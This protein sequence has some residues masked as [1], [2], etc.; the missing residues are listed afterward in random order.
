MLNSIRKFSKTILAKIILV[1]IIIPFVFW[2]MGSVFNT[3]SSNTI[4]KINNHNISTQDFLD[5]LN[6]SRISSKAIKDNLDKNILEEVLGDLISNKMLEMEIKNLNIMVSEIALVKEIKSNKNF[7]DENNKFS[8]PKY[9]KFLISQ[10]LDAPSFEIILKER[11]LKNSLFKYISGGIISPYF[12]LNNIFTNESKKID[13]KMIN[14]LNLY[15]KHNEFNDDEINDFFKKNKTTL[16]EEFIN[17]SY[18]KITPENLIGSSEYNE[19]FFEEIDELENKI[20]KGVSFAEIIND[21]KIEYV[22]KINYTPSKSKN[23]KLEKK[24]YQLRNENKI[25][26]ID[27]NDFFLLFEIS[28]IYKKI[29]NINDEDVKDKIVT[30]LYEKNKNDFN[31]KLFKK[32]TKKEFDNKEFIKLAKEHKLKILNLK[33]NSINDNEILNKDSI[34]LLYSMPEGSFLLIIDKLKNV[35]VAK[36][37]KIYKNNLEK[38]SSE[39]NEFKNKS[40]ILLKDDIYTSYDFLLNQKYKIKINQKTLERV[41]NYFR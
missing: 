14:L 40:N 13:V 36:V 1:I 23:N 17:F 28:K 6:N 20:S 7:L 3:G 39:Y 2:G 18:A 19:R 26:I 27:E 5:H 25:Q 32:I 10:N 22:E 30:K 33:I 9:E 31:F 12:F 15:K 34:N 8:R 38:S 11:I 35:Y 41:K 29:P 16:E 24:I 37:E 21:S 4:V